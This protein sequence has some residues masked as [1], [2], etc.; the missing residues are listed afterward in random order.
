MQSKSRRIRSLSLI[1]KHKSI[2]CTKQKYLEFFISE[3]RTG[4]GAD[5]NRLHD[6]SYRSTTTRFVE[7]F[8]T[9][10]I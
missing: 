1:L 5:S 9:A 3:G 8:L 6:S 10:P 2:V 4:E 7:E